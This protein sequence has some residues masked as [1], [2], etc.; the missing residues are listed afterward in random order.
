M[1]QTDG[2]KSGTPSHMGAIL[3]PKN[4]SLLEMK[5]LILVLD[6]PFKLPKTYKVYLLQHERYDRNAPI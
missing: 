2:L 4:W 5:T 6:Q 1:L 3:L